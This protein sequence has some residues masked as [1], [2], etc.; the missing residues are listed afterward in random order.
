M[1]NFRLFSTGVVVGCGI[2]W[3]SQEVFFV[4]N[5]TPSSHTEVH[6]HTVKL[7]RKEW[8]AAI[9][10]YSSTARLRALVPI[11]SRQDPWW[12]GTR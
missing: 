9:G 11:R 12:R 8:Y 5:A 10:T 1:H 4:R 2:D 3:D 6:I 7:D